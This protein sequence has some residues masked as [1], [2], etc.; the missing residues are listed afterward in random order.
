MDWLKVPFNSLQ[1][2]K[3]DETI[4]DRFP[5]FWSEVQLHFLKPPITPSFPHG[6]LQ[7]ITRLHSLWTPNPSVKLIM[8]YGSGIH[9]K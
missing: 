9:A 6:L 8:S 5:D 4:D 7:A 1:C 3:Q 2:M